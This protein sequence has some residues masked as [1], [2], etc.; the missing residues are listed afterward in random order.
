MYCI[1]GLDF[2]RKA[3]REWDTT[4][5]IKKR[6]RNLRRYDLEV[7]TRVVAG[8]SRAAKSFPA[9]R[10]YPS[11]DLPPACLDECPESW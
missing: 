7:E 3:K 6:C 8:R 2:R 4:R 11:A 1:L 5:P 10:T 9:E